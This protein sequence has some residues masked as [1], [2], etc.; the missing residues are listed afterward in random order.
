MFYND[1]PTIHPLVVAAHPQ[2]ANQIAVGLSTGAV[3]VIEPSEAERKWGLHVP[4][5]N[6]TENGRTAT[7]S[8]TN[9]SEQLQR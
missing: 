6:G 5:D 1:S 7:S 3:K 8:T 4:V 2:E 9:T